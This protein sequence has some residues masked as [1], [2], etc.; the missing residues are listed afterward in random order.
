VSRWTIAV[1]PVAGLLAIPATGVAFVPARFVVRGGPLADRSISVFA[2]PVAVSVDGCRSRGAR[3]R[4]RHAK[5]AVSVRLSCPHRGGAGQLAGVIRGQRLAG[6]LT[7]GKTARRFVAKRVA[8][9]GVALPGR[10]SGRALSALRD[11]DKATRHDAAEVSPSGHLRVLRTELVLQFASRARVLDV[12]AALRA[13]GGRIAAAVHGSPLV[14]AGIPDPGTVAVL[15]AVVRRVARM[16]GVARVARSL[17]P[18]PDDLPTGLAA[19]PTTGQL[20]GVSHLLAMRMPAAW[21]ARAAIQPGDRPLVIVADYFGN[22][23]LDSHVDAQFNPAF[24]TTGQPEF[25]GYHVAGIIAGDFGD[26]GTPA[27][28]V[29]GVFPATTLLEPLD[30]TGYSIGDINAIMSLTALAA[31][32]QS[33]HVVLNTS[34][35]FNGGGMPSDEARADASQWTAAIRTLGLQD[36]LLQATSAGNDGIAATNNSP[37]TAAV[38]RRDLR[39]PA[40][41]HAI[42]P[43][44]NT[45]V[46]ENVQD[47]GNPD[48]LA[49]CRWNG[50]FEDSNFG[51]TISAV[52]VGVYS[53]T[54]GAAAADAVGTSMSSPQAAG[55]AEYLWSIAPDLS[56][57]EIARAI[58]VNAAPVPSGCPDTPA[59]PHLDAYAS[60]L[61]LDQPGS[62]IP[63]SAP[64][65]FALLDHNHDGAFDQGDLKAFVDAFDAGSAGPGRDWSSFD[66]NGDGFTGGGTTAAF[67]LDTTGSIR[68]GST[69]I[70]KATETISGT[71]VQFDEARQTDLSILCYYAYSKLY[72]AAATGD[73]RDALLGTRCLPAGRVHSEAVA[74]SGS[75]EDDKD[76][77][78][79]LAPTAAAP[80]DSTSIS[81]A[82]PPA[83]ASSFAGTS[84]A[85]SAGSLTAAQTFDSAGA[86]TI[87]A[88]GHAEGSASA[89]STAPFPDC[90]EAEGRTDST[91]TITVVVRAPAAY[92]FT[93]SASGTGISHRLDASLVQT[94]P[95][96]ATIFSS[97]DGVGASGTLQPG[98]YRYAADGFAEGP[99]GPECD[100]FSMTA[101]ASIDFDS[102][103]RVTP[104]GTGTR[105]STNAI[106]LAFTAGATR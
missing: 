52:G 89:T 57:Q 39:D 80:F 53:N 66:L 10:A 13:V 42:P 103:L 63:S 6:T 86:L 90:T 68:A 100:S 11:V 43:L 58:L 71:P 70:D 45:L 40:S 51:G 25:H 23:A 38:L 20:D 16:A 77:V 44:D 33:G 55:L 101:T 18:Q 99:A 31:K 41:G 35:G 98:T 37:W 85:S 97:Q 87:S 26:D 17:M 93:G 83:S 22:G 48:Y 32:V 61:S 74:K 84:S 19:P 60:V 14:V 34:L 76:A 104:Q 8:P 105:R 59:T 62:Q 30:L 27:G 75:I 92:S 67:D 54:L 95:T 106:A 15:N 79:N 36:R 29:T 4:V 28:L 12:N 88:S 64:V 3:L 50:G 49:G 78:T 102:S 21:N 2:A 5:V 7:L 72:T 24:L 47:T 56:A 1:L 94:A 96:S 82:S 91:L 46:V 65:R 73:Q 69:T 81:A 9:A